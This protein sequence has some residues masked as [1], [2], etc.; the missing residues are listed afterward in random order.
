MIEVFLDEGATAAHVLESA[1]DRQQND[2]IDGGDD[3]QKSRRDQRADGAADELEPVEAALER[4]KNNSYGICEEC[5][6]IINVERMRA[7][8]YARRCIKCAKTSQR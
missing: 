3:K 2:E 8:P 6:S 4:I 7:L 1:I 5:K